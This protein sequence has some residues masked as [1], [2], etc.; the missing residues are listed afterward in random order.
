M[1]VEPAHPGEPPRGPSDPAHPGERP[2]ALPDPAALDFAAYWAEVE[3]RYAP[4]LVDHLGLDAPLADVA[5]YALA[6]GKRVRPLLAELVGRVVGAPPAAVT[7][8]AIAVEYL[9]VASVLLDD[10]PCMDDASAR[11]GAPPAHARFSEAEAILTAVALTSRS[12]ALLLGAP[13]AR[14]RANPEM[15][16]LACDTVAREMAVGQAIELR[17]DGGAGHDGGPSPE[18][19]RSLHERKT[20]SLFGLVARL[21]V[22]CGTVSAATADRLVRFVTLLGRAYQAVDDIEDRHERREAGV[23]LAQVVG[24]AGAAME[25]REQLRAA[26]RAIEDVQGAEGLCGCVDWLE[27]RIDGASS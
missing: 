5:R 23:N 3:G 26:R 7:E 4:L 6:G 15:A 19:V 11:R 9:H 1:I 16:I 10:L 18:R 27:Q 2:G 13:V 8:V 17:R 24:S 22:A 14:A 12:Y 25:A 21:V 20:A